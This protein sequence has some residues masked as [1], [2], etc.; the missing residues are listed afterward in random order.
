MIGKKRIGSK[1]LS[2]FL[3]GTILVSSLGITT[4]ADSLATEEKYI[5]EADI[6]NPSVDVTSTEGFQV[7]ESGK[8]VSGTSS[9]ENTLYETNPPEALMPDTNNEDTEEKLPSNEETDN[10]IIEFSQLSEEIREQIVEMNSNPEEV[11]LPDYLEAIGIDSNIFEIPVSWISQPEFDGTKEG[12]YIFS[13][14]F[15]EDYTV[16]E[17]IELPKIQVIVQDVNLPDTI[18]QVASFAVLEQTVSVQTVP[19]GTALEALT[20]PEQLEAVDEE[21]NTVTIPVTWK[22]EPEFDGAVLGTYIFTPVLPETCF[23]AEGV[24]IPSIQVMVQDMQ[25]TSFIAID[26]AISEQSV[27][28]GT[29]LEALTLPEQLE[30]V[31]ADG[32][33]FTIP[34]TWESKPEYNATIAGEY[35]F[36]PIIPEAYSVAEGVEVPSV[37]ITVLADK[38]LLVGEN[39]YEVSSP[40]EFETVIQ[41]ITNGNETQYTIVLKSD[42]LLSTDSIGVDGKAICIRSADNSQC[43]LSFQDEILNLSGSITFENIHITPHTIYANGYSLILGDGF[44]GGNDG[45]QRMTVYG[46]SD[47]NLTADTDLTIL[48]GVYKLIAGGNSA[49]TLTGNTHVKFGGNAR[50]PTAADGK[51]EEDMST[52]SSAGYNLYQKAEMESNWTP[53]LVSYTK[54][55]VLPYGI[56]GGGINADT[57]GTAVVEMTGGTAYQIFGGGAAIWNPNYAEPQHKNGI[58]DGDTYV[59]ITGGEVKSI[60]GGG[61]NG[62][63]AFAGDD[64]EKV[65]DDA[66]STRAVVG[67]TTHVT[68][69]GDAHVPACEQSEDA[70]T[71]GCDPAAVHG[72]SFHSTVSATEVI[73]GGNARIETGGG[74]GTGYGYGS[75]FGAGTNDIV[76]G[77][78]SV[79]LQENAR[80]GRDDNKLGSSAISQ[81]YF[82]NMTPL[83]YASQSGCYIGGAQFNYGSEIENQNGEIYAAT[84]IVNG[85][86]VDVLGI[87]PKSRNTKQVKKSIQGDVL[88]EQTGGTVAAIEASCVANK[89]VTVHGNVDVRVSG[90][91]VTNYIM[92]RYPT[93]YDDDKTI[94]GTVNLELS[95]SVADGFQQIPLVETMDHVTI[96]SGAA[97]AIIGDWKCYDY[98]GKYTENG[99]QGLV[100][101]IPFFQVKGLTVEPDAVLALTQ[102]GL[103][104]GDITVN[105]QINLQRSNGIFG[106]LGA[107]VKAPLTA[108]GTA[109]GTGSLL[110]FENQNFATGSIP[111][112]GEEYVYAKKDGSS[113]KLTLANAGATGLY[114]DRKGKT[115]EQDV[116]YIA[117]QIPQEVTVTFDKNGGDTEA[118]PKQKVVPGG[119]TVGTLPTAPTRKNYTFLGWNTAADGSGTEFIATTPVTSDITVYAQWKE[120]QEQLWYYELYYQFYDPDGNQTD[121]NGAAYNWI[122]QTHGQG[123]W[124]YPGDAV[125][126]S[127]KKFDGKQFAWD[128]ID[129]SGKETLGIHYVFDENYG[130]HRLNALCSEA[131]KDNP[132]KIYYRATPHTVTYQYDG[133][134]PDGAPEVPAVVHAGY[135]APVTVAENPTLSGYTFS[136]WKVQSP[137]GVEIKDGKLTMPNKDVVLVGTWNKTTPPIE[138]IGSIT[139]TKYVTGNKGDYHRSFPMQI[140]LHG[141]NGRKING[142]YGDMVFTDG[143]SN[144][145]L[146]DNES[147]TADG[148]PADLEY[149]VA[150]TDTYGHSVSYDGQTGI[151]PLNGTAQVTITNH[152]SGS[153]GGSNTDDDNNRPSNKPDSQNSNNNDDPVN[154]TTETLGSHNVSRLDDQTTSLTVNKVWKLDNGRERTDSIRV[155]LLRDGKHYDWVTLCEDNKWSYTWSDLNDKY[156]WSVRE[157]EVPAG[158]IAEVTHDG[159]TW[160]I[161]NDD[162]PQKELPVTGQNW[163][164]PVLLGVA[165]VVV[166]GYGVYKK[167]SRGHSDEKE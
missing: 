47:Q 51:Q 97:I 5:R 124:A 151:I 152:K 29:A 17:E 137:S 43:L 115:A 58:V 160:T 69:D 93:M 120:T 27:P 88:L 76:L 150:E 45:S 98:V 16:S 9:V 135:S 28:V 153:G 73:V 74:K 131:T 77:T 100:T 79:T 123:G 114:V 118:D 60:Y 21:G 1:L 94:T 57:S 61:Y 87:G 111:K 64:Y 101:D 130:E 147:K 149:S 90:G 6:S 112:S 2:A 35:I 91:N 55:G 67:G 136:G 70:S 84:A 165:G 117:K 13:P 126:I 49:E 125:S 68:I 143:V 50:F 155:E 103:I 128:A 82:G 159:M 72:G 110:P 95:G 164:I 39:T 41:E 20:L 156:D 15:P 30:A 163:V 18:K 63:D 75:L 78:T 122:R 105:G 134:V 132:L 81:G 37:K 157:D 127:Q 32:T 36:F 141:E 161:I 62:I 129:G 10:Q 59:T 133:V 42:I 148:L 25:V 56:Y 99:K 8:N 44:G 52:G 14:V 138:P 80:I 11:I 92:G 104:E 109:S 116:W 48:D 144:F 46:G 85:G 86:E 54:H 23:V 22:G 3:S 66:R 26:K 139:V 113:M 71:A 119:S 65:P 108:E 121:E 146:K 154:L 31:N 96:K 167:K 145:T 34:V 38:L 106:G 140:T 107:G 7:T 89:N 166:I 102:K 158:F 53:V 24:E 12:E 83:G 40:E 33:V 162:K 4:F 19:V 142:V